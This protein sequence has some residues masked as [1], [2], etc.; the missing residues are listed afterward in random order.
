MVGL[1]WLPI[2]YR[3]LSRLK[4]KGPVEWELSRPQTLRVVERARVNGDVQLQSA[5]ASAL[6]PRSEVCVLAV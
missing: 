6:E 5:H 1:A 3:H 2:V 4:K